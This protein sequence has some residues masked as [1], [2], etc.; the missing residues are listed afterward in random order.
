MSNISKESWELNKEQRVESF[1][2]AAFRRFERDEEH[3]ACSERMKLKWKDN[4]YKAKQSFSLKKSH[5][6]MYK[7]HPEYKEYLSNSNSK[8]WKERKKDI[9]DK[10]YITKSKNNSWNTSKLEEKY[11]KSLLTKYNK[12][13]IVRQYSSDDRYP[14]NC[15]FY[16][17]S[18]DRFI[19]IQGTWTHGGHPFDENNPDDTMKLNE[20][21]EKSKTSPYYMS[22]IKVWTQTDVL[23]RNIAKKNNINIEFIY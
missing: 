3:I 10:Q 2:K 23:K 18:E 6:N 17:K 16:I 22:A 13:D 8:T 19:E 1:S 20:W 12:D 15:D 7:E 5:E 9:L 11:Y 4:E 14:F 21:V